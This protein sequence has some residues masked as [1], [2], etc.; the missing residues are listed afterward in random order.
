MAGNRSGDSVVS[1]AA[2][3]PVIQRASASPRAGDEENP[4]PLQPLATQRPGTSGTGP[5]RNRPSG[6]IVNNPPRCSATVRPAAWAN[7]T[8]SATAAAIASSTPR[9]SG[10]SSV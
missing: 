6:L 2:S 4:D 8:T 9:S 7:G 1:P 5:A 10:T 3:P